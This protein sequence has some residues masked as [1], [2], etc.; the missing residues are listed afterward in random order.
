MSSSSNLTSGFI[1]LATYDEIEKYM[2]GGPEATTYFVRE[3][4][5][6]TWFTHVPVQLS[7]GTGTPNFGND[8]SVNISRAGDYLLN[9]WLRVT[10]PSLTATTGNNVCWTRNLGH[11][12]IKE[13]TLRFNDLVAAK[14]DHNILDFWSAFTVGASKRAAYDRMIGNDNGPQFTGDA[15]GAADGAGGGNKDS[16]VVNVPLPFFF[17]RDT[18]V[19]LPTAALPYNEMR[20]HITFNELDKL[21]YKLDADGAPVLATSG[22]DFNA[23]NLTGSQVNVWGDYAIVSN[24][25]RQKMACAPR[26][27]LIEQFQKSNVSSLTNDQNQSYDI[28]FSHAVKALMFAGQYAPAGATIPSSNYTS[29]APKAVSIANDDEETA[30]ELWYEQNSLN[31]LTNVT[32]VYENTDRLTNMGADYFTHV[33]PYYNAPNVPTETGYHLYSYSLDMGNLDPMGSTNYGKLTNVSIA[34]KTQGVGVNTHKFV[35]VALNNNVVRVSGG[36]LGFPVL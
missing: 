9:C 18:G 5:R 21:V 33:C 35:V 19:A 25:E 27:M 10:V 28:R 2:Y 29:A 24:E 7:K 23:V 30:S 26:D 4:R 6:S 36:A 11:N 14:L 15:A 13:A 20:I 22:T 8:F 17:A 16:F 31:P 34:P 32:L 12:L 3:T 1:D